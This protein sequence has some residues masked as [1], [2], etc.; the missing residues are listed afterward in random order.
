MVQMVKNY[1]NGPSYG[2]FRWRGRTKTHTL[3]SGLDDYPRG[4]Y[5]SEND[6]HADLLSWMA[7]SARTLKRLFTLLQMRQETSE[8]DSST[9]AE[10]KKYI[11][12][13]TSDEKVF[14][15]ALQQHW[16]DETKLFHDISINGLI[17]DEKMPSGWLQ[18]T[19][20][21]E[22]LWVCIDFPL[23]LRL[24]KPDDERLGHLIHNLRDEDLVACGVLMEYVRY[25]RTTN[26]LA[27][28]KIIGVARYG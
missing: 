7:Y 26:F 3:S 28:K 15:D 27:K 11:Q 14:T 18:R 10:T 19:R 2:T 13:Y 5:P 22:T 1:S 20:A 23:A 12:L 6:K 25:R 17:H 4:L 16:D 9:L 8:S 24:L 21:S